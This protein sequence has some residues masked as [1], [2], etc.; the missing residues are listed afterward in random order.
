M[1]CPKG[2]DANVGKDDLIWEFIYD[3]EC[4]HQ[5]WDTFGVEK[6]IACGNGNDN[7]QEKHGAEAL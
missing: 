5:L 1:N 6:D 2:G 7:R 4:L 3:H